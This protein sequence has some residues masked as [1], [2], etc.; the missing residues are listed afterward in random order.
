MPGP[1]SSCLVGPRIL[2]SGRMACFGWSAPVG[3]IASAQPPMNWRRS[4]HERLHLVRNGS[5]CSGSRRGQQRQQRPLPAP[6]A[7]GF[8]LEFAWVISFA[9]SR[10]TSL[11]F[12]TECPRTSGR[13][14]KGRLEARL[15]RSTAGSTN[16]RSTYGLGGIGAGAAPAGA[17]ATP[18][19]GAG[20]LTGARSRG[21][22]RPAASSW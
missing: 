18:G 22:N 16:T 17:G 19:T 7:A 15:R 4:R 2:S 11:P 3:R 5:R 1:A 9:V 10:R 6:P 14:A 13:A 20:A 12:A 8:S 21:C